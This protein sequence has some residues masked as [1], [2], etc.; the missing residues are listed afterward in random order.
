MVKQMN[1]WTEQQMDGRQTIDDRINGFKDAVMENRRMNEWR[2]KD[3]RREGRI[4]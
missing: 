4:D 1:S 3:G 2:N